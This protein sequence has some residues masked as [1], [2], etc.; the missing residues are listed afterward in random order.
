MDWAIGKLTSQFHLRR[1][2]AD[3]IS[4]SSEYMLEGH[5]IIHNNIIL[6]LYRLLRPPKEGMDGFNTS[7]GG[8]EN[9]SMLNS[10]PDHGSWAPF[11]P[12]GSYILQASIRVQDGSKPESITLGITELQAFKEMMKG[13]VD[14][15]VGD[16]LAMD[17]RVR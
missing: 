7:A 8:T 3:S 12:S 14:L 17:T 6:L 5:R 4:Y 15:E 16:R 9:E 10:M 11:D 2:R 1:S 13:V